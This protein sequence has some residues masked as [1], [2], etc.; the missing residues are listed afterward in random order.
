ME[1]SAIAGVVK[2]WQSEYRTIGR[3]PEVR[4]RLRETSALAPGA[5]TFEAQLDD[6]SW[7]KKFAL[8]PGK[9]RYKFVVDGEWLLD[10]QNAEKEQNPFGTYDSVKKL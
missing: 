7:H 6:G 10:S 4:T 1:T 8:T 5:R 9:Y 2:I 3:M